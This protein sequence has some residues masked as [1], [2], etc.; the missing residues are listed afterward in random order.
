MSDVTITKSDGDHGKNTE[1]LVR[2]LPSWMPNDPG[3]GN[4]NLLDSIGRAIDRLDADIRS[5]DRAASLQE[6]Q[7]IGEVETLAYPVE[8]KPKSGESLEKYRL[9]T[10]A[11]FQTITTEGTINEILL[12]AATLLGVDSSLL[13]YEQLAPGHSAIRVPMAA[14]DNL[15]LNG[16]A[17]AENLKSQNAASYR[18]DITV[19][20][21]F[22]YISPDDYTAGTHD[23]TIGYDG[24]DAN[25]DPIGS[26]GTYSG[27]L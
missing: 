24:L 17:F 22:T 1:D 20:G 11:E 5:T 9:R 12:N 16:S 14:I 6:A 19:S 8:T 10:M 15:A 4:F 21:T 3:S 18:L 13:Y 27:V 26:G 25:G 7:S 2:G 23:S